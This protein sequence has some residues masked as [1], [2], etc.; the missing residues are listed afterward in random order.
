HLALAG[1]A[2]L[3]TELAGVGAGVAVRV[4]VGPAPE[5][6]ADPA[7]LSGVGGLV[8]GGVGWGQADHSRSCSALGRHRS[9][10]ST[11]S[12]VV[13][14]RGSQTSSSSVLSPRSSTLIEGGTVSDGSHSATIALH[15]SEYVVTLQL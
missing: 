11:V 8:L 4:F 15:P 12:S 2:E 9:D 13:W 7:G 1:E 3:G 10:A 5:H 14:I 6:D